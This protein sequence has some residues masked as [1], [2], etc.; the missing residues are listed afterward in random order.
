MKLKTKAGMNRLKR[1][2]NLWQCMRLDQGY[3]CVNRDCLGKKDH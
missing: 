3:S 1:I 2:W